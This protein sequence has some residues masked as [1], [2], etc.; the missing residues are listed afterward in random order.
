M[1][2][3]RGDTIDYSLSLL[4]GDLEY[5]KEYD[6]Q[7]VKRDSKTVL[8]C[9]GAFF[10]LL[11]STLQ[12]TPFFMALEIHSQT[13]LYVRP[14]RRQAGNPL[15]R[16]KTDTVSRADAAEIAASIDFKPA[17]RHNWTH[18]LESFFWLLL[19]FL[20]LRLVLD[21]ASPELVDCETWRAWARSIFQATS[22]PTD[23][24]RE[25]FTEPGSLKVQLAACL[26]PQHRSLVDA[27]EDLRGHL[28]TS[29]HNRQSD[30]NSR[31][32]H[33][34]YFAPVRFCLEDCL[35]HASQSGIKMPLVPSS[36]RVP[37]SSIS[38]LFSNGVSRPQTPPRKRLRGANSL[39]LDIGG[40]S[41]SFLMHGC[42]SED[43][44]TAPPQAKRRK[45]ILRAGPEGLRKSQRLAEKDARNKERAR[46]L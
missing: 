4:L 16:R 34:P 3:A 46:E 43:T 45:L 10:R 24:R 18:D 9:A 15:L 1:G 29:H 44:G 2:V 8:A 37:T 38:P 31:G 35:Q 28:W 17:L 32:H 27:L 6:E 41:P 5:A 23:E 26:P 25:I 7:G 21:P 13:P 33:A 36:T 42:S 14:P 20:A 40:N 19:W 39:E 22:I 30:E 12:G 11:T